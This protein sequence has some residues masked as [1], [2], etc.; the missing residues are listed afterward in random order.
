[1]CQIHANNNDKFIAR[2]CVYFIEVNIHIDELI[3]GSDY[4]G[5]R[6]TIT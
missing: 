3:K 5:C 2:P 4:V 1:M 6:D